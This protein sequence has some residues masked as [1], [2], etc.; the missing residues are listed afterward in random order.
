MISLFCSLF[1]VVAANVFTRRLY[2]LQRQIV[3][4][5]QVIFRSALISRAFRLILNPANLFLITE[6]QKVYVLIYV[7]ICERN[8]LFNFVFR[9]VVAKL[10]LLGTIFIIIIVE[11]CSYIR[12]NLCTDTFSHL[13]LFYD[14]PLERIIKRFHCFVNIHRRALMPF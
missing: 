4:F 14:S 11:I 12:C 3:P 7:Q 1:C 2:I 6:I 13:Y 8:K 10:F 9:S 5:A